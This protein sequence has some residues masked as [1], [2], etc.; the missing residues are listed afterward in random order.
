METEISPFVVPLSSAWSWR[1]FYS[2]NG[3]GVVVLSSVVA[4]LARR[5][6]LDP[7]TALFLWC[8]AIAGTLRLLKPSQLVLG[9]DGVVV[10]WLLRTSLL[11][12]SYLAS[13]ELGPPD[14]NFRRPRAILLTG[15][16][17][18]KMRIPAS[19]PRLS[20][21]RVERFIKKRLADVRP[22][23]P[24]LL[25]RLETSRE[26]TRA[27]LENPGGLVYRDDG[28]PASE[29]WRLFEST[30]AK[31]HERAAAALALG[32]QVYASNRE[33]IETVLA[34]FASQRLSH[35]VRQA[36]TVAHPGDAHRLLQAASALGGGTRWP[37]RRH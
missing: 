26:A 21:E 16:D 36:F 30:W 1:T 2:W 9:I 3:L 5:W 7:I 14:G 6:G 4:W 17:G 29:W 18:R 12:W 22:P 24:S 20:L 31:P 35:I 10:V 19:L 34:C 33:R 11:P 28:L 15:T 32:S 37:L 23:V 25:A 8:A 27:F 13:V